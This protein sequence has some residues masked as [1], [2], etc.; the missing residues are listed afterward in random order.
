[1]KTEEMVLLYHF[2][3]EEK[4]EKIKTVL[5]QMKI[6]VKEI[7]DDLISQKV[8]FLLGLKGFKETARADEMVTFAQ[9]VMLMQGITGKRMKEI[10]TNFTAAGIEKIG[11]KAV[12]T[13]YN[14]LWSL[15]HLCKTIQKERETLLGKIEAR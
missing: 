3:D 13:P 2:T 6:G 4:T 7:S 5:R 14:V 15:H 1:M 9:E 8:G 11:L 10:L 12:V